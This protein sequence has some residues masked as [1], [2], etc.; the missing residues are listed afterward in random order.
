MLLAKPAKPD[1]GSSD[2]K[3]TNKGSSR[4]AAGKDGAGSGSDGSDTLL[5]AAILSNLGGVSE[6]GAHIPP[7]PEAFVAEVHHRCMETVLAAKPPPPAI[8]GLIKSCVASQMQARQSDYLRQKELVINNGHQVVGVNNPLL[9]AGLMK[10]ADQ[11]SSGSGG[12]KAASSDNAK[13]LALATAMGLG[14]HTQNMGSQLMTMHLLKQI[15]SGPGSSEK[16]ARKGRKTG[17][18]GSDSSN[19]FDPALVA[20][21]MAN[22]P[23]QPQQ[24][25]AQLQT[26]S[27]PSTQASF[28]P[29]S[30]LMALKALNGGGDSGS[31]KSASSESDTGLDI[32]TLAAL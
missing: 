13:Y 17:G 18:E 1:S 28:D 4:K 11:G 6:G 7:P 5:H 30:T 32:S 19:D 27:V 20:M 12:T 9:L 21:L 10:S 14:G 3:K 15:T 26:H 16:G 31:K 22:Q 23:K 29:F 25:Q 2:G 24:V 8:E